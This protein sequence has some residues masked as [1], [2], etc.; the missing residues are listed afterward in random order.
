MIRL[1]DTNVVIEVLRGNERLTA[2]LRSHNA[3][4]IAVSSIVLHELYFG[5]YRSARVAANVERVDLLQFNVLEFD[6]E[7][8]RRAGE[9]RAELTTA[10]RTIGAYDVLIA[11]QAL[12]R[13]LVLVTANTGEFGR[14]D[15]LQLENWQD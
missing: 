11:G 5:A 9:I 2:R 10:G 6:A 7:D 14:I 8:A 4:E 3:A 15:G 1:L 12:S 13:E